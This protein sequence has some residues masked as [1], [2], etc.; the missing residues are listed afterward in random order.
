MLKAC[1]VLN[2]MLKAKARR[3]LGTEW[4]YHLFTLEITRLPGSGGCCRCPTSQQSIE[5]YHTL[6]AASWEKIKTQSTGTSL[7]VQW[8]RHSPAQGALLGNWIPNAATKSFYAPTKGHRM[9]QQRLKI[10]MLQLRPG[11]AKYKNKNKHFLK[12][13]KKLGVEFL[14]NVYHFH[15]IVK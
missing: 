11:R 2:T 8:L 3:C 13:L 14:L 12:S 7:V 15:T 1:N 5:V 10:C 9:P 4:L 6:Y